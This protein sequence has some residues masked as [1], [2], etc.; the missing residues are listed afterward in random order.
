MDVVKE[1]WVQEATLYWNMVEHIAQMK[2]RM[3]EVMP[4]IREHVQA[5]QKSQVCNQSA[6]VREFKLEDWVLVLVSTIESKF[7]VQWPFELVKKVGKG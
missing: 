3:A 1:M 5:A 6:K 7:L 4:L 2:N